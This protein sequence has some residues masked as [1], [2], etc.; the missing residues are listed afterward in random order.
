MY[1]LTRKSIIN[2][3]IVS[4]VLAVSTKQ[5]APASTRASRVYGIIL[6]VAYTPYNPC[7]NNVYLSKLKVTF[8]L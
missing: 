8:W 5:C 7:E 2:T 4:V 6:V 1:V 3:S